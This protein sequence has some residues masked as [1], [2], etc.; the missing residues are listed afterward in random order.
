MAET[1]VLNDLNLF[2][3]YYWELHCIYTYEIF[4][5]MLQEDKQLY[6]LY[7][8][9]VVSGVI[10]AEEFWSNRTHVRHCI[11][12]YGTGWAVALF[13]VLFLLYSSLAD[14]MASVSLNS[15]MLGLPIYNCMFCIYF[16]T[17]INIRL[18]LPVD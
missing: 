17:V 13:I 6:Q 18:F 11:Y 1:R 7:N 3:M 15:T 16:Y 10:S 9:L 2:G 8:D 5:R 14:C 12:Q 4:F